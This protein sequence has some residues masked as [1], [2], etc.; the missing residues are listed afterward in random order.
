MTK[1]GMKIIA[2]TIVLTLLLPLS[3]FRDF[4]AAFADEAA[5][6]ALG[7][8]IYRQGIDENG[9]PIEAIVQ[10]DL[11]VLGTEFTCNSCHMRAGLGS[12]EGGVITTPTTGRELF[13]PYEGVADLPMANLG[14]YRKLET[15]PPKRPAYDEAGIA[16]AIRTGVDPTGRAFDPVMPR[17]N[18]GDRTMT[19]LINYLKQ[20]SAE[21]SPGITGD[22]ARIATV[23]TGD[24]SPEHK[25]DIVTTL[26]NFIKHLNNTKAYYGGALQKADSARTKM[27]MKDSDLSTLKHFTLDVW[28]LTGPEDTWRKQLEERYAKAPVFL[29]LGG[30]SNVSW[31][32]MHDFCEEKKI[33]TLLPITDFP[34]VDDKGWYTLYFSKSFYTEADAA[35]RYLKKAQKLGKAEKVLQV[36]LDEPKGKTLAAS[37]RTT[38]KRQG[39]S[40]VVDRMVSKEE[41]ADPDLL[42]KLA[43]SETPGALML[44]TGSEGYPALGKL[45]TAN[46]SLPVFVSGRLLIDH[47]KDMPLAARESTKI[48]YPFKLFQ[49]RPVRTAAPGRPPLKPLPD[50]WTPLN[51][52]MAAVKLFTDVVTGIKSH[53]YRDYVFDMVDMMGQATFSATGMGGMGGGQTPDYG[54]LSFGPGQRYASKGCYIIKLGPEKEKPALIKLSDWILL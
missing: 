29:F 26:Q 50:E 10:G 2:L 53:Y 22:K 46:P 30:M 52:S 13:H 34:V 3:A 51:R 41:L 40:N 27:L 6:L 32:P 47:L 54:K 8:R 38:W 20:L 19:L 43:A 16:A 7:E 1:T 31:K 35:A 28:E 17:Y 4:G 24:V 39:G 5:D 18:L 12:L 25:K 9:E 15:A 36:F 48:T 37:F 23:I 14:K 49:E 21:Y 11:S 42:L 33:P 44:W 45:S